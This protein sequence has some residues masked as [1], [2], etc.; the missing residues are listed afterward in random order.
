MNAEEILREELERLLAEIVE[1]SRRAGQQASGRTYEGMTVEHVS[2]SGG[3]LTGPGYVGALARGR[4][5]GKV[6]RDFARIIR[7]WAAYKGISFS[8]EKEFDRWANAVAW[9][10]RREGTALWREMGQYGRQ[11]DI[12]AT[13]ISDF[14]ERLSERLAAFYTTRIMERIDEVRQ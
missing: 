9:K 5:A 6:P 14:L 7:E 13:P 1:T 2:D 8:S 11:E 12:F 10:I 4:R 3:Q